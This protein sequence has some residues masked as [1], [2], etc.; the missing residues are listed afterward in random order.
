MTRPTELQRY[1]RPQGFML[2]EVVTAV[3]LLGML[4]VVIHEFVAAYDAAR[5]HLMTHHQAQLAAEGYV[6]HIRAGRTPPQNSDHVQYEVHQLPGEGDWAG[7]TRLTVTAS[8]RS[9]QARA[10]RRVHFRLTSYLPET[11]P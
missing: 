6:E 1:R 4:L 2:I 10:E 7:L 3:L 5:D 8:V 9:P 11:G